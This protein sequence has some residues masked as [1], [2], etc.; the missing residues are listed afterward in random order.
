MADRDID[1]FAGFVSDVA[2]FRSGEKLLL[3]RA[4]VVDAWRK[5]FQ[6]GAAPFSWS[7]D[8][9]TVNDAGDT[10]VSSGPVLDAG[11]KLIGRFTTIW[12]KS[13]GANGTSRWQVIVDQGVPLLECS[14]GKG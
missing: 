12:R 4:A 10:A 14:P 5:F 6:P 8:R 1:A 7:P 9:V 3:G 2:V 13:A 11:G